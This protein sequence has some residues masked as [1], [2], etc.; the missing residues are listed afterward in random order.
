[1]GLLYF[2]GSNAG[3]VDKIQTD[4]NTNVRLNTH[5]E[6]IKLIGTTR[7]LIFYLLTICNKAYNV[8]PVTRNPKLPHKDIDPEDRSALAVATV[9]SKVYLYIS[10]LE[11]LYLRQGQLGPQHT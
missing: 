2:Q 3:F 6:S 4:K 9:F 11:G 7:L 8:L 5:I 1:M 10:E